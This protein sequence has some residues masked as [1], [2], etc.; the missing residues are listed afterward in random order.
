MTLPIISADERLAEPRGIKGCIFG[1]SGIG[2]TSLLWTL[3]ASTT[4]FFDLEAGDLAI[5]GWSGDTIRP[6]TWTECRD[7]AVFIGGPNP[8][9]R[10]DQP[11]SRAHFEAVCEKFGD[12][13]ALDRFDT[14]FV[15]SITVAGRL[16]FQWCKGQPEA[17]SDKTG[18]PDV[19]GA[20][21]LHGREMIAWLTHLQHTRAR[22]VWFVGILDTKLDDFNRK[23]FAPQIDGSKT[24]LELPGIVDE[25]ITMAELK[26]D[27]GEPYRAF[28]CQTLNPWG[29][30]AKDRSGRLD[31]VEEPHLG[32]LMEKIRAP[33]R[34][35]PERLTY[36]PP[37]DPAGA[38]ASQS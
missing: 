12:P 20:Y 22:N 27:G 24:G 28:V 14:I 29:Y 19:R 9:L 31:M 18:K 25:V 8:A 11:Y 7:F 13:A 1:A 6:R 26:A 16:C 4:L 36:A 10:D 33:G 35:A 30:P 15:D 34:P 37:A 2:K 32:R 21:G 38:A 23:V 3:D 17:H 5:E